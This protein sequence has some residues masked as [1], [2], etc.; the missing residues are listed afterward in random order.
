MI[1][2]M[3]QWIRKQILLLRHRFTNYC[4]V[5]DKIHK[6]G[7]YQYVYCDVC[8]KKHQSTKWRMS[9][10][11]GKKFTECGEYWSEAISMERKMDSMTPQQVLSGVH[12][13]MPEQK[14]LFREETMR[15][16]WVSQHKREK[17]E[18]LESL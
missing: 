10:P 6:Y 14:G 17:K 8:K 16:G 12:L 5:C 1:N 18:L 11:E 3:K 9:W 4:A 15:E 13:G 2:K 7:N